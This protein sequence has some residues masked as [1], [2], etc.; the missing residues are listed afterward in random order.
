[1]GKKFLQAD[2]VAAMLDVNRYRVY[3]LVRSKQIP[4]VRLG[5]SVRFDPVRLDEWL[6]AGGTAGAT[7][8]DCDAA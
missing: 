1:M 8:S 3:E 4:A 6:A 7:D 2:E 5:R